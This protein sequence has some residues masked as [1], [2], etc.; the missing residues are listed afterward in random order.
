MKRILTTA[1]VVTRFLIRTFRIV[2]G[3][4]VGLIAFW[5]GGYVADVSQ[6]PLAQL[7]LST[8]GSAIICGLLFFG[9]ISVAFS[10]A[11]GEG[12]KEQP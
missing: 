6:I 1:E 3:I 4:V 8:I 10:I 2:C 9:L 11:F 5:P 12:P 7:T